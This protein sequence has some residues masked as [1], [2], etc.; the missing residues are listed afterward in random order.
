MYFT[1]HW[2]SFIDQCWTLNDQWSLFATY[3]GQ[4]TIYWGTSSIAIFSLF[5]CAL[6]CAPEIEFAATTSTLNCLWGT[7]SH[8][9]PNSVKYIRKYFSYY[10]NT[11]A[12][13]RL[14]RARRA[15]S[16]LGWGGGGRR[17]ISI[18]TTGYMP[19]PRNVFQSGV[20]LTIR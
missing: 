4:S 11:S 8:F 5:L 14:D 18:T 10:N 20:L 17:K 12:T 6:I 9:W 7:S 13:D 3:L 2:T 15:V 16:S 19:V 1:H